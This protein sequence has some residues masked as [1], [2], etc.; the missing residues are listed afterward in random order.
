MESMETNVLRVDWEALY[1]VFGASYTN[2]N[3]EIICVPTIRI[4]QTDAYRMLKFKTELQGWQKADY[5]VA[6]KNPI[7]KQ[8]AKN[9]TQTDYYFK[10]IPDAICEFCTI[11]S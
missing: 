3:E 7:T 9:D 6:E 8:D 5:L 4:T 2:T 1:Q 10:N 11:K